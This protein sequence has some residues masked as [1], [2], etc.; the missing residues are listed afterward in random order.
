MSGQNEKLEVYEY[1]DVLKSWQESRLILN[2]VRK[3]V[4]QVEVQELHLV[5]L[6]IM[7]TK[8]VFKISVLITELH[9]LQ[10]LRFL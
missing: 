5:S 10:N 4:F 3:F 8:Y 7:L 1:G 2:A 6:L 9:S